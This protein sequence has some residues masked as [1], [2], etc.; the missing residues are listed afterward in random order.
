MMEPAN[1]DDALRARV[2][3]DL[4]SADARRI[5]KALDHIDAAARAGAPV[6][7]ALVQ[8]ADAA[9]A[10]PGWRAWAE[11]DPDA[12]ARSRADADAVITD[13]WRTIAR[14]TCGAG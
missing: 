12:A 1:T 13:A 9:L 14:W 3:E 10:S 7:S 11:R 6:A 2:R 5:G 4:R 8:D